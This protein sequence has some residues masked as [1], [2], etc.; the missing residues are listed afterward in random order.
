M[1][2]KSTR[3]ISTAVLALALFA[4]FRVLAQTRTL[5]SHLPAAVAQMTPVGKLSGSTNLQLAIGLPL[6]NQAA[7]TALLQQIYDPHSTNYH[8][9]LT[10]AQFAAQFG[11]TK[12]DYDKVVNFAKSHGLKVTATTP[13]R[14]LVDVKGSAANVEKALNVTLQVYKHPTENRTFYAPNTGPSLD[15]SL[16][17]AD[18][19]GL[20]NYALPHPQFVMN[21]L[22]NNNARANASPNSGSGPSGTYRGLDFRA[23]Y[24][25][26]VT[27]D[28]TGQTVG[29]LQFDG[30]TASDITYYETHAGL[31]NVPLQNVLLDGFLG[32]PTGSGG[33]V[34]V[35]LDIEMSISM[36]TN[37]TKVIVYMAGPSGDWHDILNRMATDNLAK[38]LSCSW[39]IPGGGADPVADGIFQQ[40]AVQ[41]QSFYDASGDNDAYTGL[42]SFAGDSPYITQVGGTTLSTTG[43]GG[44]WFS[45]TTWNRNNG[46]GTGGGISTQ[47]A[48]PSWQTNAITSASKGSTTLRNTPDVAMTA[49]NVYVRADGADHSVGGTSCAAP[50][51]AG[52]TALINQ[53]ALASGHAPIGFINP[54][55]YAI[56]SSP[57]Y[58][59]DFHDITTGN[60]K[61]PTSPSKFTAVTGYDL[62]T[63]LGTPKGQALINALANPE[64]L[65]ITPNTGF[66]SIGGAGGPFTVTSQTLTLTN[67]GTNSLNWSIVNT[68]LW[69]TASSSSGTLLAHG[70]SAQ[71]AVSFNTATS[72]LA[73]GTYSSTVVFSNRNDH[74][75]QGLQYSLSIIS[76]PAISQQPSS[77]AALDGQ[78]AAFNVG[79]TGGQPMFYHWQF[80]GTNLADGGKIS[81]S[82]SSSLTVSNV[83][84][85]VAGT[86]GVIVSNAAAT[87][88]SSNATLSITPSA[89]VIVSLS[90]NQTVY[91]TQ[92]AQ[93]SVSAQGTKPFAYRWTFNGTNNFIPGATNATLALSNLQL[94]QSGNYSIWITNIYGATNSLPI[95]LTVNPIPPCA[96]ADS[97]IVSWWA[98]E[99][100][101]N[102]SIGTNNGAIQGPVTFGSGEVGL[103]FVFNG[104]NTAVRIPASPSL[105]LG[106]SNGLTLEAWIN[107]S[108]AV[109]PC[110]IC[111]WNSD[112]A[113]Y[114]AAFWIASSGGLYANVLDTSGNNHIFQTGDN[115]LTAGVFQHVALV[116]SKTTGVATLYCNAVVVAQATLGSFTPQTSYNLYLGRRPGPGDPYTLAG[117]LDEMSAYNRALSASEIQAI[118]NAGSAGKCLPQNPLPGN[119]PVITSFT[120]ASGV[121]GAS[122]S[123]TGLNFSATASNNIIYFGAVQARVVSASPTNLVVTVPAGAVYGPITETTHGLTA[124]SPQPFLPTFTGN[125]API[126]VGSF[127]SRLDLPA[128]NGP[129]SIV[130]IDLDGDGKPDLL[131]ANTYGNSLSIFPN[132]STNGALSAASFGPRIDLPTTTGSLSP[133]AVY[134]ADVDGDGKPDLIVPEFGDGVV[135]VYHNA[136]IPG[137]F[138]FSNR[139]DF[140]T[141]SGPLFC[142]IRDLDG[143][144]RPDLVVANA[145]D[146]TLSIF[147]N[148]SVPGII[149]SNSFAPQTTI[150][151]GA[152]CRSVAIGDLDG[153]GLPDVVAVNQNTNTISLL[154]N[155]GT[156]GNIAFAPKVD[157]SSAQ[158]DLDH[159]TIGDLD[160]D[161]KPD[162]TVVSY[163]PQVVTVFQNTSTPGTLNTSSFAPGIPYGQ[164]GWGHQTALGDLNGDGKPDVAVVCEINSVLSVYQNESTPGVFTNSS[165]GPRIDFATGYNP[166]G[167]AIGDL[168]GDGRPE[169]VF[170]NQYDGTISIYQNETPFARPPHPDHFVWNNVVSPRF[171]NAPFAVSVSAEDVS[172]NVFTNF[173][174]T[175]N[176]TSTNGIPVTPTISGNFIQGVW[177]GTI[178][179]AQPATNLVLSADD[180]QGDFGL[181]NPVNV[182]ATPMLGEAVDAPFMLMYWQVGPP[183]FILQSTTNLDNP[184]WQ[185]VVPGPVVIQGLNFVA[186][187]STDASDFFRLIYQGP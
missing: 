68:S 184:D 103:A 141:G 136:S 62:C 1:N 168:D 185:T 95:T 96:T 39:Y 151:T 154:R 89:P 126:S 94:A 87:L 119:I 81:G 110:P 38:Q 182:I 66:T 83:S 90:S 77:V 105:N 35:S 56:A 5:N 183:T 34:E 47:Y 57:G 63:G 13:N 45:E 93:F 175:V 32:N 85:D 15:A 50:L 178:T 162:L 26:G 20:N 104:T 114:G 176:L 164:G 43:P 117:S 37:L 120:P 53:Q 150:F 11:P 4:P 138:N 127:A 179:I 146:G 102:D 12:Q 133:F 51:W 121:P 16:P 71:V 98:G 166:W 2:Q 128:A 130:L 177:N 181:A 113:A 172:N 40:M 72:N 30:Y 24:V 125:G 106:L 187:P 86:Y 42:I 23:A 169:I 80:N 65:V 9:Y 111:E 64:P 152:G 58:I 134:A 18:I 156:I 49:E 112:G 36:A 142:A 132:I 115:V 88:V 97:S 6:R 25:P 99:A 124:Y 171:V 122:V 74:V 33:E 3:I 29:L 61:S 44:P 135:S 173:S 8:R 28:G 163:T 143:D 161:G 165:L 174:G 70:P 158:G 144:G 108:N 116:Y 73:V 101:V 123:I 170:A 155:V 69:L 78:T 54:L 67:N 79:T 7:L 22:A 149:N 17:I 48:I 131:V 14:M 31:P 153:D 59:T 180:G 109:Q 52:F 118:Y 92:S 10:P 147:H 41:G 139:V 129:F 145:N 167:I 55:V 60:N 91:T 76:P 46:I 186:L 19:S 157:I 100:N 21:P 137:S 160:G 140:A 27:L 84:F 107:P 82:T 148:T 159:V 75:G